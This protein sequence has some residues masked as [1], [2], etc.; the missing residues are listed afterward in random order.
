MNRLIVKDHSR[1]HEFCRFMTEGKM[2]HFFI[3]QK[4]EIFNETHHRN[5]RNDR[6]SKKTIFGKNVTF[7]LFP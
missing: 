5:H 1:L 4:D 2:L 7:P 3:F 6:F